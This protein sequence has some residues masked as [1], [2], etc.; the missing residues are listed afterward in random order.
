M[1]L[2]QENEFE[3]DEFSLNFSYENELCVLLD[4]IRLVVLMAK[5]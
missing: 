1:E 4:W 5:E 2:S 3:V